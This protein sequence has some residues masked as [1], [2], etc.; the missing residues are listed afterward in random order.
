M[1][2]FS[3]RGR[4]PPLTAPSEPPKRT[5]R[6]DALGI[7]EKF[8]MS[9]SST[10][11]WQKVREGVAVLDGVMFNQKLLLEDEVEVFPLPTVSG[12]TVRF[13]GGAD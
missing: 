12:V 13:N 5:A 10:N 4:L 1:K 9:P 2:R 11:V 3:L 7:G 6:F 8:R